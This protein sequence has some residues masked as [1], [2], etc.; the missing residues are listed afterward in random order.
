V[1]AERASTRVGR[2]L[3]RAAAA[4]FAA[5]LGGAALASVGC[6]NL[7]VHSFIGQRYDATNDCLGPKSLIDVVDGKA[8][9]T[10]TGV[11]CY[12]FQE[13][14]STGVL[15]DGDVYVSSSCTSGPGFRDGTLDG[16]TSPC[17]HALEAY[18]RGKDGAC[19]SA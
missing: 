17:A 5:A 8:Q 18:A 13:K 14:D 11:R 7:E 19:P 12:V 9:G 1:R 15:V 10:C 16:D 2:I 4:T 6:S 3:A